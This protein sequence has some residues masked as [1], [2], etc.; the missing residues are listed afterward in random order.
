MEHSKSSQSIGML[1]DATAQHAATELMAC[2]LKDARD[3]I[4]TPDTAVESQSPFDR[5]ARVG[6]PQSGRPVPQDMYLDFLSTQVME[7]DAFEIDQL[8]EIVKNLRP[9]FETIGMNLPSQVWLIKTTGR[10][11]AAAAYTRHLDTI[12]L[13]SNMVA[14]L[15]ELPPGGDS[16]HPAHSTAYLAGIVT[17]EL[18]HIMSKNNPGVRAKLYGE[19]GFTELSAPLDLPH[20]AAPCGLPYN[21]LKITNPDAPLL[22]VSINLVPSGG[23]TEVAMVPALV[24]RAPYTGGA[25]FETLDWIF[26]ELDH[27]KSSWQRDGEGRV[28]VH[29]SGPLMRQYYAKIG[30]NLSEEL[31]H[32]DE[33][34]AQSFVIAAKEPSLRLL[35]RLS[36]T[37]WPERRPD[38]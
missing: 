28:I 22:N 26:F 2:G 24:S 8:R 30:R 38:S 14:S 31:F 1:R 5:C 4:S 16:L 11:E 32:P 37:I 21:E 34:L 35:T 27:T 17:H 25:F 18:F 10:E 6:L 13:P 7:W 29:Q 15:M 9:I 20:D 3:R 36:D 19:L 33:I 12:A 23:T